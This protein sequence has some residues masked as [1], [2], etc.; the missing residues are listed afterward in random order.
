MDTGTSSRPPDRDG[1][2]RLAKAL[3]ESTGERIVLVLR[4]VDFEQI[5]WREGRAR[6]LRRERRAT[7]AFACLCR[8]TLREGDVVAHGPGSDVFVAALLGEPPK[9]GLVDVARA[10]LAEL[11][12]GFG[13]R[14]GLTLEAGWTVYERDGDAQRALATAIDAALERGRR[15]RERIAFFAKLGHEMRSPLMSVDGYLLTLLDSFLDDAA[16]RRFTEAAHQEMTRLRRLVDSMYALSLIDLDADLPCDVACDAQNAIERACDAI[17][18]ATARRGTRLRICNVVDFAI[19]FATEHAV[20]IFVGFLDNAV[21]HGYERGRIEIRLHVVGT[22]LEIWFDDDGPGLI[23]QERDAVFEPL[24][25]GRN[26]TVAG[27]GLGLSIARAMIERAGGDVRSARSPLG[28]ARF[29]IWL[30][31]VRERENHFDDTART[32]LL[33]PAT[34]RS[35]SGQV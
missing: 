19:P 15:N 23:P 34:L 12:R 10:V 33:T 16:R 26:T 6:A 35:P 5:A 3:A 13:E 20:Q 11:V 24:V 32:S 29:T 1:V 8:R 4:A 14:T 30:P 21:K 9:G 27:N 25:R 7:E 22:G 17:Y 28:G 18:P 2:A 31:A